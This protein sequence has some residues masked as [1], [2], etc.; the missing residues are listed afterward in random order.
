M[1]YALLVALTVM[2]AGCH[3]AIYPKAIECCVKSCAPHGGLNHIGASDDSRV[4]MVTGH[5]AP[6]PETVTAACYCE[7]ETVI[8]PCRTPIK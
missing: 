4:I 8:D 7:D 2:L 5:T 1:K 6:P 3:Y